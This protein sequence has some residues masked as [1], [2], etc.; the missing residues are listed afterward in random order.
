MGDVD[1]YLEN[2]P[3]EVSAALRHIADLVLEVAPDAEQGT[4]YGAPT[5]WVGGRPLL[6]FKAA[7]DHLSLFV[8]DPEIND[9]VRGRLS[10]FRVTKG[11][12]AF[13]PEVMP[14]D[15]VVRDMVRDRLEGLGG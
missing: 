4:S 10:G 14:P 12:V 5:F 13:T 15:D 6:G 1:A 8:F 11:L 2:Q 7:K 9:R 3:A